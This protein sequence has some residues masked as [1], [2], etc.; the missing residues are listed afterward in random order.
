M[1]T[2]FI[3]RKIVYLSISKRYGWLKNSVLVS[4][5]STSTDKGFLLCG[6]SVSRGANGA[7]VLSIN[8]LN[9]IWNMN[10]DDIDKKMK[11]TIRRSK[12]HNDQGHS[13]RLLICKTK[14]SLINVQ[15][16]QTKLNFLILNEIGQFCHIKSLPADEVHSLL[17]KVSLLGFPLSSYA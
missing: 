1:K 10:R 11:Y 17:L 9:F 5:Y 15:Y 8:F 14:K 3:Q 7:A 6:F 2:V 4:S 13:L 12:K 16:W